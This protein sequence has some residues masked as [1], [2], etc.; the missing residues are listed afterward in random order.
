MKD[1]LRDLSH[2][3]A[4]VG[5]ACELER[6]RLITGQVRPIE[7]EYLEKSLK[8]CDVSSIELASDVESETMG[9]V[10]ELRFK[11]SGLLASLA[12]SKQQMTR[13]RDHLTELHANGRLARL[14][15]GNRLPP[16]KDKDDSDGVDLTRLQSHTAA[17]LH[18]RLN[19]I[20]DEFRMKFDSC[21][22]SMEDM[23]ATTQVVRS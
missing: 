20:S 3:L 8:W 12:A 23:M 7:M 16:A 4:L 22:G 19:Q 21:Q 18:Q 6:D 10:L 15:T 13:I 14:L 1:S 17:K 2:P 9:Q 5:A 11:S